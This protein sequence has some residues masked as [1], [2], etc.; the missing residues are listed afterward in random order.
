MDISITCIDALNYT[1]TL[2]ALDHTLNT[3]KKTKINISRVYW[4][5]DIDLPNKIDTE[6][7][8]IRIDRFKKYTNEYNYITLK[9]IPLNVIDEYNL[10]IHPDGFAVNS[11]SWDDAFLEYDYIGARWNNNIIGNGGFCLRSRKLYNALLDLNVPAFTSDYNQDIIN[12]TEN[13]VIDS[14]GDKVIPEDNIICKIYRNQLENSY[15]IKFAPLE[16]ADKFSIEH[17]LSSPWLG[18]SFGFH[19]KHGVSNYYGIT[20]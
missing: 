2:K 6:V 12:N 15:G 5:S 4:F 14:F 17:H 1:N 8:W 20:L 3:F 11:E 19:G 13:Y 10:I 7:K 9:L 16:L 18:K